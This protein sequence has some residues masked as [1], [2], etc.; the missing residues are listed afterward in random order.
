MFN[1]STL[2]CALFSLA[3]VSVSAQDLKEGYINT[4]FSSGEVLNAIDTWTSSYKLNDD[5]HFYVS[6]IKSKARFRNTATQVKTTLTDANDKRLLCWLPWGNDDVAG[7]KFNALPKGKFDNEIFSM[8][9]YVDHWGDWNGSLARVPAAL[10]DVAHKNGVAVSGV[11]GIPQTSITSNATYKGWYANISEAYGHKAAPFLFYYGLSGMGYNSE[12]VGNSDGQQRVIAFHKALIQDL[13]TLGDPNAENIWYD[14]TNDNGS[15]TFDSQLNNYQGLFGTDANP[16]FSVFLNYNSMITSALQRVVSNA[17]SYGRSSLYA[18][19]GLNMQGGNPSSNWAN[20]KNYAVSIGLWGAHS[21]NMFFQQRYQNG[22]APA[23]QQRTYL[24]STERWFGGGHR[25]PVLHTSAYDNVNYSPGNIENNPGMCS[26]M[27]ARSTLQWNLGEEPFVTFF[28]LG[29]GTFFN[30]KGVRANNN[31]WA[32]VG[33]QDYLPT[34]RFWFHNNWL[35]KTTA[36]VP[37]GID[38]QFIWDDAYVGGSCLEISGTT[39]GTYLHLFK[40]KFALQSGDEITIRYKLMEGSSNIQLAGC[41][42]GAESTELLSDYIATSSDHF[43]QDKWVEKK[44]VIGGTNDGQFTTG[45]TLAVLALK[46]TNAQNLKLYLGELSITRGTAATPAAPNNLTTT[47]LYNGQTGIDAKLIWDMPG[48]KTL[49]TATFNL[50][51]NTSLFKLYAQVDDQ[52]PMLMGMTQTWAGIEYCVPNEGTKV[53]FGVSAVSTDFASESAITWGDWYTIADQAYTVTDDIATDKGKINPDEEFTI[54]Y[55]DPNHETA[56]WQILNSAGTVVKSGTGKFI[57]TS[58]PTA[59]TYDLKIIGYKHSGSTATYETID[60]PGY[61]IISPWGTGAVPQIKTLTLNDE[62]ENVTVN[63]NEDNTVKFTARD[64]DGSVSQGVRLNSRFF[65][66]HVKRDFNIT[67]SGSSYTDASADNTSTYT[68]T[69]WFK[70]TQAG[71][72]VKVVDPPHKT[73]P[74]NNWGI[75]WSTL[76]GDGSVSMTWRGNN[77]SYQSGGFK[78]GAEARLMWPA[79]TITYN[80]WNHVALIMEYGTMTCY[81]YGGSSTNTSTVSYYAVHPQLYVNGVRI[82]PSDVAVRNGSDVFISS[83]EKNHLL[84]TGPYKERFYARAGMNCASTTA[85]QDVD[86]VEDYLVLGGSDRVGGLEADVDHV[87]IWNKVL[88]EDEIAASMG[89]ITSNLDGLNCLFTFDNGQNAQGY[90]PKAYG[91][92]AN[93]RIALMQSTA[94]DAYE[95]Q[96]ILAPTTTELVAGYPMLSGSAIVETMPTWDVPG[97]DITNATI[98]RGTSKTLGKSVKASSTGEIT[99]QATVNWPTESVRDVTLTLTNDYGTDSKTITAVQVE[100]P[101]TGIED[102]VADQDKLQVV[103]AQDV[104]IVR[105]PEAGN[106]QF[107]IYATDGRIVGQKAAALNAGQSVTI[108]LPNQGVYLLGVKK[109]GKT[110]QG[111]KFIRE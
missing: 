39:S 98:V 70:P 48:K 85:G 25:N 27:S 103:T 82:D 2:L 7:N 33:V 89:D 63:V 79:G 34:W 78:N 47:V 102:V 54:S 12:F 55:T 64:S 91:S 77:Y 53:R 41:Y 84:A 69:F 74:Q 8:W 20:L 15:N 65:G 62:S 108:S 66:G 92:F 9:S 26:M 100:D 13:R 106:Y 56:T 95:G 6:R 11:A 110:L 19:G 40:T 46:L 104:V 101:A 87:A 14:G 107:V 4:S 86:Q 38:A 111:Y 72:F 50:D 73:W 105:V 24:L 68:L 71:G 3:A 80:A 22:T 99:G 30:W 109:D 88:S 32:N 36:S 37:S 60:Y 90:F 31:E 18:Y 94:G 28:N 96:N 23:V 51:V 81:K 61:I 17:N 83:T 35:G 57:T 75:I 67:A 52:E 43:D 58:L 97:A 45:G 21:S 93:G 5:D 10:T 76:G 29:N 44:I 49:P 42:E 16:V 59:G 1:K